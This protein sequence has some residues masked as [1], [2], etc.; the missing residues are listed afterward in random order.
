M[1]VTAVAAT[2]AAPLVA[3]SVVVVMVAAAREAAGTA[4]AARASAVLAVAGRAAAE[5]AVEAKRVAAA[6]AEAALRAARA[7]HMEQLEHRIEFLNFCVIHASLTLTLVQLDVLWNCCVVCGAS[8]AERVIIF[9]WVEQARTMR[10]SPIDT[11]STRY[12][13]TRA[14]ELPPQTLSPTGY[15][16]IEYLFRWINWCDQRLG[17]HDMANFSVLDLP[18]HGMGSLWAAALRARD[19]AV[20]LRAVHFLVTLHR[21]LLID[22]ARAHQQQRAFVSQCMTSLDA[23]ASRLRA[24]DEEFGEGAG[25][26]SSRAAAP[27][28]VTP[29]PTALSGA[30]LEQAA[31]AE[32]ERA[33][34]CLCTERCLTLL[35]LF[36]V[37]VRKQTALPQA[38]AGAQGEGIGAS[39]DLVQA[40]GAQSSLTLLEADSNFETLFGLLTLNKERLSISA[41]QLL[42]MLP[43]NRGM[44]TGLAQLPSPRPEQGGYP[45]P[46]PDGAVRVLLEAGVAVDSKTSLKGASMNAMMLACSNGH[47]AAARALLEAGAAVD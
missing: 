45:N 16:C 2:E 46:K 12:L 33:Q 11:E 17:Q 41:W 23:A 25:G 22:P 37:E 15:A 20:G 1:A 30:S 14:A 29:P 19:E 36:V 21:S 31:A 35:R 7:E 8:A 10:V 5:K 39:A 13:F 28:P 26:A 9:D 42:M 27:R 3:V 32:L 38:A 44:R 34:L 4:A 47:V 24:L 18:L 43:T 40:S 6:K